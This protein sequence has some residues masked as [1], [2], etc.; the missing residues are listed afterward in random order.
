[1]HFGGIVNITIERK[2]LADALGWVV[3]AVPRNP[4][5]AV[6]GGVLLR[7]DDG[8]LHL[9]AFDYERSHRAVVEAEVTE[10]GAVLASGRF[11][12]TVVTGLK[13]G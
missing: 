11:L 12:A 1:L 7:T 9:S 5:P 10:P 3:G 8:G 6:L 2:A 13:G 4:D